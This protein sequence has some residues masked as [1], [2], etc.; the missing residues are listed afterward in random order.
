MTIR[1]TC[2]TARKFLSRRVRK[3]DKKLQNIFLLIIILTI[4]F[5]AIEITIKTLKLADLQSF[6]QP[7]KEVHHSLIPNSKGV[8]RFRDEF[9]AVYIINSLGMRS[10]GREE[11]LEKGK[12][13][14]RVVFIGDSFTEGWGLS[15]EDTFTK[16]VENKL[17]AEYP[18]TKWSVFNAGVASYSPITE[19]AYIKKR[20]IPLK[21]DL[22]VLLLDGSDFHDD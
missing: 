20:I 6:R 8:V 2:G 3:V 13:E 11:K 1:S 5:A 18:E 7:D 9:K 17:K 19:Y 4:S 16:L 14:F 10:D 12:S 15:Y 21:P 22:V